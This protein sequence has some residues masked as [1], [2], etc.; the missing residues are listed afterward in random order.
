MARRRQSTK[1]TPAKDARS[2]KNAS[3]PSATSKSSKRTRDG[4]ELD[5]DEKFDGFE[6]EYVKLKAKANKKRKSDRQTT[7]TDNDWRSAPLHA[8]VTSE[9]PYPETDLTDV[10][11]KIKPAAYWESTQRYR[12]FTISDEE[13]QVGQTVF[14]QQDDDSGEASVRHWLAKILEVRAADASH[15][16]LRVYWAY[17]PEDL[18]GGRQPHHGVNELIVSNHMDIIE[19][20]T[21]VDSAEVV[22][23]DDDPEASTRPTADQLFWRQSFDV[24][25]PKSQQLS[26]SFAQSR[27][28]FNH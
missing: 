4:A 22:Y 8:E 7:S 18:P 6:L 13:F 23:W 27:V 2:M 5:W 11:C 9:N 16:F 3:S 24:N 14:V 26:V 28:V 19:A 17:R 1:S 10:H 12:K 21:V 25:K 15:V 20:V